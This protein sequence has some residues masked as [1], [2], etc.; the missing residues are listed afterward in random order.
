[1]QVFDLPL[2]RYVFLK[3]KK[4]HATFRPAFSKALLCK[5]IKIF[6]L[7]FRMFRVVKNIVQMNK[8]Y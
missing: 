6:C 2:Y 8:L 1:M 3:D 4:W 5:R 7:H